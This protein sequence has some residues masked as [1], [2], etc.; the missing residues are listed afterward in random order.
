MN[1]V[2]SHIPTIH[3]KPASWSP[4]F[5]I[6]LSIQPQGGILDMHTLKHKDVDAI[7]AR[8]NN[9]VIGYIYEDSTTGV[10]EVI[11]FISWGKIEIGDMKGIAATLVPKKCHNMK[12]KNGDPCSLDYLSF[13]FESINAAH[14]WVNNDVEYE[15][16]DTIEVEGKKSNYA[17][18]TNLKSIPRGVKK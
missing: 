7:I 6:G 17:I 13:W 4:Q 8:E 16:R 5:G 2:H 9:H 11:L 10:A 18:V 14:D 12:K 15:I 3:D 1:L